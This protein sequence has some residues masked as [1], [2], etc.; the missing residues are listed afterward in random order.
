MIEDKKYCLYRHIRLDKNEVFYIGI[1]NINRPY[2]IS[3]RSV[4]WKNII[5]K[6]EYKVEVLFEDLTWKEACDLEISL[7]WLYG[8]R[9]KG[10]GTLCNLTDGGEGSPGVIVSQKTR[11]LLSSQRKNK[12]ISQVTRDKISVFQF[13]DQILAE[14]EILALLLDVDGNPLPA[15]GVIVW[16]LVKLVYNP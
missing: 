13:P 14:Y 4:F 16:V 3:N 15:G 9:D 5:S 8:R 7:I 2:K 10:L 1:G 12:I 11:D 6:T